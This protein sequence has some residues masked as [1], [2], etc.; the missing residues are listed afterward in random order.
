FTL[1][2]LPKPDDSPLKKPCNDMVVNNKDAR[3]LYGEN[4]EG[5]LYYAFVNKNNIVIT[6]SLDALKEV[7]TRLIIKNPS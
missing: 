3:V 4:R 2:N 7:I 1:F 6:S 5:L